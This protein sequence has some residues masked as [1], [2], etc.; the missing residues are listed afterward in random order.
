MIT[1]DEKFSS[2]RAAVKVD[3]TAERYGLSVFD[4]SSRALSVAS[5]ICSHDRPTIE[6]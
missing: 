4:Y 2:V 1:C 3:L 5:T 6:Y